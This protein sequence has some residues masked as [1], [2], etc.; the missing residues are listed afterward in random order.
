MGTLVSVG[1]WAAIKSLESTATFYE[2]SDN[3]LGGPGDLKGPMRLRG[4]FRGPGRSS[5][6]WKRGFTGSR[7]ASRAS[8]GAIGLI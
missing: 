5:R 7:G 4:L 1:L 6:L 8:Q 3:L 2:S